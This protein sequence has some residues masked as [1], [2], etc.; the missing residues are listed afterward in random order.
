MSVSTARV[1][2]YGHQF[3]I[4]NGNK[5]VD[6]K[7]YTDYMAT[8]ADKNAGMLVQPDLM[9]DDQTPDNGTGYV[10]SS[11]SI[12]ERQDSSLH[13][14]RQRKRSL[15][16]GARGTAQKLAGVWVHSDAA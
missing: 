4:L 15:P 8:V 14:V 1:G 13:K 6:I 16:A 2:R 10:F 12:S 7:T 11:L 5:D 3:N 9:G